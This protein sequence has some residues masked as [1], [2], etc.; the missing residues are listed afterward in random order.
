MFSQDQAMNKTNAELK[1][2]SSKLQVCDQNLIE[3]TAKWKTADEEKI[4]QQQHAIEVEEIY[5]KEINSLQS[6]VKELTSTLQEKNTEIEN[7]KT[8]KEKTNEVIAEIQT[9]GQRKNEV[10]EELGLK[11]TNLECYL[12]KL[13]TEKE[14]ITMQ[15]HECNQKLLATEANLLAL[16][17]GN[18]NLDQRIKRMN[19]E[20]DILSKERENL[21][22]AL[23]VS[24]KDAHVYQ[25]TRQ[26]KEEVIKELTI[27]LDTMKTES[28]VATE[29]INQLEILKIE[30]E[31]SCQKHQSDKIITLQE[32]ESLA[33][34]LQEKEKESSNQMNELEDAHRV[35][36]KLKQE[37]ATENQKLIDVT[38]KE[39]ENVET[40]KTELADREKKAEDLGNKTKS[41]QSQINTKTKQV[42]NME[43]ENKGLK[44]QL[45]NKSDKITKLEEQL[46]TMKQETNAQNITLNETIQELDTSKLQLKTT[47]ESFDTEQK[48]FCS[49]LEQ[50]KIENDKIV[51]CLVKEKET[52]K[53]QL[54]EMQRGFAVDNESLR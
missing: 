36:E 27:I 14:E 26:E 49:T 24:N 37:V 20:L 38:E 35:I 13:E 22:G 40:I 17:E 52:M 29:R 8:D 32:I 23:D 9:E 54:E 39:Q 31:E 3:I 45:K 30:L 33:T 50:Y 21:K 44:S 5:S 19:E 18:E 41:L 4:S 53:V 25:E 15:L 43:K 34:K 11:C 6:D 51:E 46:E 48:E 7:L 10:N 28:L 1:E 42:K 47:K 12:K 2:V 16:R